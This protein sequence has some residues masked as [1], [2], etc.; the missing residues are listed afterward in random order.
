MPQK[1]MSRASPPARDGSI[2]IK[3]YNVAFVVDACRVRR[4]EGPRIVE[5]QR[6]T[7]RLTQETS[8]TGA[9]CAGANDLTVIVDSGWMC[10]R[11]IGDIEGHKREQVLLTPLS[12]FR[13][14]WQFSFSNSRLPKIRRVPGRDADQHTGHAE[15]YSD[16]ES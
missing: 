5:Q 4:G 14:G 9:D 7:V 2:V 1:P 10:V 12:P 15:N 16:T 13:S 8:S 11:G 3:T 6:F